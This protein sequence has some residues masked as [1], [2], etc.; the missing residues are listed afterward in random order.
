MRVRSSARAMTR[1]SR[2]VRGSTAF[3]GLSLC[4]LAPLAARAENSETTG[5]RQEVTDLKHIIQHLNERVEGLEKQLVPEPESGSQAAAPPATP[6]AQPSSGLF[7]TMFGGAAA[8]APAKPG[9]SIRE[10][11]RQI[12]RGMTVQNVEALIGRPQRTMTVNLKTV[13][14]YTYQEVGSGSIVFAQDGSVD[15]WQT[16]PFN[17][18]W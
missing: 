15:D 1:T 11:W 6:A 2:H 12:D 14:Y 16:P 4:L 10:R 5:L 8:A 18:W 7:G 13:W 9:E 17:T 3:V